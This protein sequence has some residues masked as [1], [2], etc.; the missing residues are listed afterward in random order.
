MIGK[1]VSHYTILEKLGRGGMSIVYKAE[2]NM[3]KRTEELK[4]L[5]ILGAWK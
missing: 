2:E 1:K 5:I 3:L 4:F